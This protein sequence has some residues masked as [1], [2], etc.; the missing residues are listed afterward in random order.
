MR[1]IVIDSKP[2]RRPFLL[3]LY[4]Q[5]KLLSS[6]YSVAKIQ[7]AIF[8]CNDIRVSYEL[9]LLVKWLDLYFD[10]RYRVILAFQF[11]NHGYNLGYQVRISFRQ[12]FQ[13]LALLLS[14]LNKTL[15]I[16]I[17]R[18]CRRQIAVSCL[19]QHSRER[20]MSGI[21]RGLSG[22]GIAHGN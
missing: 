2:A 18:P 15:R 8:G 9:A 4:Q 19:S 22:R 11:L 17:E 5:Q 14:Q 21:R 10:C 16:D 13:C 1:P 6:Q 7:E 12:L 20:R 3:R